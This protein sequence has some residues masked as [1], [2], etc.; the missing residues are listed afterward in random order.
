MFE[1]FLNTIVK[2]IWF[3]W[4]PGCA[5]ALDG[6]SQKCAE[7]ASFPVDGRCDAVDVV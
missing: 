6:L 1:R 5:R 2:Q 3:L 7:G 4:L